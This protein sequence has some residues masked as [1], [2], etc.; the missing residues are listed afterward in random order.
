METPSFLDS[1]IRDTLRD[2][3]F[4][5]YRVAVVCDG[6]AIAHSVNI[7]KSLQREEGV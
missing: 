6:T 5:T 4:E 3:E 7:F 1:R 2:D